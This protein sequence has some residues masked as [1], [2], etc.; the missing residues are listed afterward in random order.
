MWVKIDIL[1]RKGCNNKYEVGYL[2]LHQNWQK[3]ID[4]SSH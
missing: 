2:M 4:D 1:F 3:D